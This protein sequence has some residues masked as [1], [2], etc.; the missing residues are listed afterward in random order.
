M[1]KNYCISFSI[2]TPYKSRYNF[3]RLPKFKWNQLNEEKLNS[4]KFYKKSFQIYLNRVPLSSAE[5]KGN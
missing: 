5:F 1:Q 2:I 4:Y 3:Q